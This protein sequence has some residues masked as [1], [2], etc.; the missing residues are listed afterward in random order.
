MKVWTAMAAALGVALLAVD[1]S[2]TRVR[3]LSDAGD[4]FDRRIT[5]ELESVGFEVE[6][7]VSREAPLSG[8]T[9]AIVTVGGEPGR[10]EVWLVD[11]RGNATLSTVIERELGADAETDTTR[12]AER[13]RALL[14]PLAPA[15]EHPPLPSPPEPRPSPE[16]EPDAPLRQSAMPPPVPAVDRDRGADPERAPSPFAVD[17]SVA[18]VSQPGGIAASAWLGARHDTLYPFGLS[19][20]VA[21]PLTKTTVRDG[22][23]S[24]ELDARLAG[25]SVHVHA[26]RDPDWQLRIGAG[27]AAAWLTALGD[28]DAPR[29]GRTE[30]TV[31]ALPFASLDASRRLASDVFVALGIVGGVALPRTD[32]ELSGEHAGTWGRPLLLGHLGIGYDP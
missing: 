5:A 28:A 19:L 18:G 24:A 14:Q 12:V 23:A 22:D 17:V 3:F 8:D 10:V 9:V 1:A 30:S 26:I 15:P 27:A 6:R 7:P 25:V 20:F 16:P 11:A 2:A 32:V 31:A 4:A 29:S 21:L 13:L